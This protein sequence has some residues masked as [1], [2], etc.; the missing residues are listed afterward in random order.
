MV[1]TFE[2]RVY[3]RLKTVP[4]GN[5]TTYKELAHSLGCRAYRRIG[6][7]MAKNPY[8]PGVPCH[9][10]VMSDGRLGGYSASGG[11]KKKISLLENEGIKIDDNR[12]RNFEKVFYRM[13]K[14]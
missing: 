1:K 6:S 10:V 7:L 5:V 2:E 14:M 8:A 13:K 11:I 3:G 9:R 12:I 4:R